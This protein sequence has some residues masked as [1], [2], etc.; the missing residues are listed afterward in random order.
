[1]RKRVLQLRAEGIKSLQEQ[2]NVLVEDM[3]T[4]SG[5]VETEK[6]A[7]TE[8]EDKKF[9]DLEKQIQ[10][11]DKTIEK[12]ERA[13]AAAVV[14]VEPDPDTKTKETREELEERAFLA[15]V[16]G[17][18]L[19]ERA[20]NFTK[21]DNGAVI[22]TSIANKII[23][24]VK[25]ISPVYAR[26][27]RYN[28]KGTLSIPYYD[29]SAG[30]IEVAYADEF[31]ELTASAGSFKSIDLTGFLAASLCLLSKSL[32][33]NSQIDILSYVI[34]KMAEKVAIWI[35]K[36]LLI[37]TSTKIKGF[38]ESKQVI[39]AASKT[40]LTVDEL[41]D[42]QETIPDLFQ[43]D[44]IWV[45]NKLTRTHIRKLKDK[46]GNYLLNRDVSARWGYTLLGKDVY[47]SDNM[48]KIGEASKAIIYYGDMSGLAVKVSEDIGLEVLREKY[49]TQHAIGVVGWLE[50]DAKVENEQKIA[51]LKTPA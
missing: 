14:T 2:R 10:D 47:A 37:G 31:V 50:M 40:A 25:E 28:A 3:K 13:R 43:G 15:Y 9:S 17:E 23:D 39:T 42:L 44:A 11:L 51:K 19:E 7:F 45:M 4:L 27:T 12:L 24:K 35:E 34:N 20:A 49:A 48:P 21:S 8:E 26:A 41:I 33:N 6:R 30:T 38:S 1:M 18:V 5:K 46:D 16:K 29:E 32:I 22:P 36:E